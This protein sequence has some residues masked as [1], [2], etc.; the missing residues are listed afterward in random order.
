MALRRAEDM[1]LATRA[2]ADAVDRLLARGALGDAALAPD[3][4]LRELADSSAEAEARSELARLR[5]EVDA[6]D[7]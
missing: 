6:E 4:F 1:I 5:A 7:P 3:A 2:R